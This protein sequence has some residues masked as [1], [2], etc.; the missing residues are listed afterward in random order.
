MSALDNYI[1][2]MK[3]QEKKGGAGQGRSALQTG[4]ALDNY[5]SKMS[6]D[7]AN[8]QTAY[9]TGHT[10]KWNTNLQPQVASAQSGKSYLRETMEDRPT[11]KV[12]DFQ[13]QV[14]SKPEKWNPQETK[15]SQI[16]AWF[17]KYFDE[18]DTD[19]DP[20][21]SL[22]PQHVREELSPELDVAFDKGWYGND[23]DN[24]AN[25]LQKLDKGKQPANMVDRRGK[26]QLENDGTQLR[27]LN[28]GKEKD[29]D[30]W[31][32]MFNNMNQADKP[33]NVADD[34]AQGI[35]DWVKNLFDGKPTQD[36][37]DYEISKSDMSNVNSLRAALLDRKLFEEAKEKYNKDTIHFYV[38]EIGTDKDK[39]NVTFY[40]DAGLIHIENSH[41][42]KDEH[43]QRA[44]ISAIM[45]SEYY[46]PAL[47]S[48]SIETML[49]EWSGHNL[50][51]ETASKSDLANE[52]YKRL[53]FETPVESSQGVDFRKELAPSALRNYQLATLWGLLHW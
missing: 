39:L 42:I 40:P 31:A 24:T 49:M 38:N 15:Q 22:G 50:I 21:K 8:T 46:D 34:Q 37:N 51:Y 20:Y 17:D 3:R 2:N 12:P 44:I 26:S 32:E 9:S 53:G 14:Q 28:A 33:L 45:D 36:G 29:V 18:A 1:A 47:Y 10:E 30:F 48:N 23:G 41:P 43:E 7:P 5:L 25:T 52:F 4:S 13:A 19:D 16:D 6:G 11:V 27:P 35:V